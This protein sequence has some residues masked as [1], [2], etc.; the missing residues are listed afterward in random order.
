MEGHCAGCG[1]KKPDLGE[2]TLA[3]KMGWRLIRRPNDQAG[4]LGLVFEWL[5][6]DCAP[7]RKLDR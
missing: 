1:V 3:S 2:I 6:P 5:C 4:G 7:R